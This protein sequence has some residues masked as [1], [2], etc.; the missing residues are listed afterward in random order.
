MTGHE[1]YC[2]ISGKFQ[3]VTSLGDVGTSHTEMMNS[4]IP[5]IVA[6]Y[7]Q[8]TGISMD[9]ARYNIITKKNRNPKVMASQL[10]YHIIWPHGGSP[11]ELTS[12]EEC[13]SNY[14]DC[15]L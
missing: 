7:S 8:P 14:P 15:C 9:S 2:M 1:Y 11:F 12:I 5:F 13:L 10:S 4:A 3:G 6:L